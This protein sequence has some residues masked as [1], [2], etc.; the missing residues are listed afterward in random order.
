MNLLAQQ[1]TTPGTP[2]V[3]VARAARRRVPRRVG[4]VHQLGR[5]TAPRPRL[6]HRERPRADVERTD[7][8]PEE[9]HLLQGRPD[10]LLTLAEGDLDVPATIPSKSEVGRPGS[11]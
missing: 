6:G 1:F 2:L 9:S 5:R 4:A 3:G 10:D 11:M 8:R 7:V